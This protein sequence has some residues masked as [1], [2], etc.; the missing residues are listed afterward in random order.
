MITER[1]A[2][3]E[4]ETVFHLHRRF[5]STTLSCSSA[6][7]RN[8]FRSLL[9]MNGTANID[10]ASPRLVASDQQVWCPSLHANRK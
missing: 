8:S 7:R 10:V 3:S 5:D 9:R 2:G 6:R 4:E 1:E